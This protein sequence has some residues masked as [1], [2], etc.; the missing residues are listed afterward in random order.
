MSG[1]RSGRPETW[2]RQLPI[3]AILLAGAMIVVVPFLWM[4]TTS[5]K[6]P[7]Q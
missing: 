3:Q 1:S 5:L 7:S 4:L 2:R 6:S